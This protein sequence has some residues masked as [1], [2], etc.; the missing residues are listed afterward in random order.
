MKPSKRSI[1]VGLVGLNV[2]LLVAMVL[3]TWSLPKAFAQRAGAAS[4][5][6]A[7]TCRADQDFDVVYIVDLAQRRLM[8]FVPDRNLKG[9]MVFGGDRD[10]GADFNRQ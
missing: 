2:F 10:L 6:I 5:Y 3:S 9:K 8:C 1:I 4:N 7:V